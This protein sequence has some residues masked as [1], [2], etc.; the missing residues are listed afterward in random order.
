MPDS[1]LEDASSRA[2]PNAEDSVSARLLNRLTID[3]LLRAAADAAALFDGDFVMALVFLTLV[4][5]T[6]ADPVAASQNQ[7]FEGDGLV[8]DALRRPVSTFAVANA[9]GMPRET[10]RR[11]INRLVEK[12][13]CQRQPDRR[14]LVTAE[15]FRRPEI[16]DVVVK[17]HRNLARLISQIRREAPSLLE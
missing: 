3:F 14:L 7:P 10:V 2:G 1:A 11:Y 5:G 8:P 17:N 6:L 13:Y 15:M 16:G 9:L 12:G 4:K